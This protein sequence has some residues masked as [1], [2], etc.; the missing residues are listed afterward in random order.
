MPPRAQPGIER[1][2]D[3]GRTLRDRH[4]NNL[5]IYAT[6]TSGGTIAVGDPVQVTGA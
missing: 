6:I 3:I 4:E 5:G 2:L 1:D